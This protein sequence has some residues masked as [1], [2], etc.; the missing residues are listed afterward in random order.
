MKHDKMIELHDAQDRARLK[1]QCRRSP[2]RVELLHEPCRAWAQEAHT[3][4][5]D[6]EERGEPEQDPELA[7]VPGHEHHRD[8]ADECADRRGRGHV[9]CEEEDIRDQPGEIGE[10]AR[11]LRPDRQRENEK[12]PPTRMTAS[13]TCSVFTSG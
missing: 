13:V 10:V 3:A 5:D 9:L 8:A 4:D 12:S 6:R 2:L 7:E 11:A 1:L